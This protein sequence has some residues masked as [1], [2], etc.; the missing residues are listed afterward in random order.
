VLTTS[1]ASFESR[2][3]ATSK[4]SFARRRST[5]LDEPRT[6]PASDESDYFT[7]TAEK[8]ISSSTSTKPGSRNSMGK[9][10]RR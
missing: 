9:L 3:R 7:E 2:R 10:G 5:D 8:S 4:P 1:S 6:G